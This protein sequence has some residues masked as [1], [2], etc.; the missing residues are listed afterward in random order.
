MQ[1]DFYE[2]NKVL[3]DQP[4]GS[5]YWAWK[6]FIILQTMQATAEGDIIIYADAGVEFVENISHITSRLDNIWLFANMWQHAHW[7]KGDVMKDI[8]CFTTGNQAQASV[9]VVRN[10]IYSRGF[11]AEWME[12]CKAMYLIDDSTSRYP[13]HPEFQEHRHD[14]AILTTLA[15]RDKVSFHWWPAM[16]NAGAFIYEKQG[17]RDNYPVLFHHHRR[18][19]EDWTKTDSL[20]QH[21]TDY[22][23]RR[24]DIADK[25]KAHGSKH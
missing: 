2:N 11:I 23:T 19:N 25:I 9:I 7:C 5:G 21:I 18:R 24:Y 16:Y 8:N 1:T 17:F 4:R 15:Y 13:N 10:T 20:N 22:F 12:W 6:P 14:Q 3:L